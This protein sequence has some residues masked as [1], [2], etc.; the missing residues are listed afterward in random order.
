MR[1]DTTTPRSQTKGPFTQVHR[2]LG[3]D[4]THPYTSE[5]GLNTFEKISKTMRC[6]TADSRTSRTDNAQS[7]K[8]TQVQ[9][10]SDSKQSG[11]VTGRG[12]VVI[13]VRGHDRK[14]SNQGPRTN[15]IKRSSRNAT[16][17]AETTSTSRYGNVDLS[18]DR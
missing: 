15:T 11:H 17:L 9:T 1:W 2:S 12:R 4:K 6:F 5:K 7:E 3:R 10:E 14:A 8:L 16:F 13:N 18:R